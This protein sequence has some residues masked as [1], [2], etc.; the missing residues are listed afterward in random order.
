MHA[1]RKEKMKIIALILGFFSST[2]SIYSTDQ[3]TYI[4]VLDTK[5][6]SALTMWNLW[7]QLYGCRDGGL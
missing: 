2:P 5:E 3:G 4:E 7:K 6:N 1:K